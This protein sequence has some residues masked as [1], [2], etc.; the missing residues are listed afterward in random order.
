MSRSNP[1]ENLKNPASRFYEFK[2]GTGNFSYYDKELKQNVAIP[3]PFTFIVID[4]KVTVK[5]FSDSLQSGFWSNE[6]KNVTKDLITVRSKRG[7]EMIGTWNEIKTKMASDGVEYCQS[8]YIGTKI[9]G[10]NLELANIQIKGAALGNWI[11]F[12]KNNDIMKCAVTVKSAKAA[13]KGA[14]NYF[15]PVFEAIKITEKTNEEAIA[16]DKTLQEYLKVYFANNAA[17]TPA[18]TTT[19]TENKE[20]VTPSKSNQTTYTAP[21]KND[22]PWDE[23]GNPIVTNTTEDNE[24]PF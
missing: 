21:V 20:S 13:K 7:V 2:G 4:E 17:E 18:T 14:T 23:K 15:E 5:G 16:L 12:R 11:E 8:V 6:V 22:L 9:D 24:P 3:F 1:N 19:T 10:K